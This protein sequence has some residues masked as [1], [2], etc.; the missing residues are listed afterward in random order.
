MIAIYQ[1]GIL[2][3]LIAGCTTSPPAIP[4]IEG[5]EGVRV[6]EDFRILGLSGCKALGRIEAKDGKVA[7]DQSRYVGTTERAVTRLKNEA[8]KLG[9]DTAAI[10]QELESLESGERNGYSVTLIGTAYKCR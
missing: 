8:A 4:V 10:E 6:V 9:G 7:R 2:C 3:A 5:S 1:W